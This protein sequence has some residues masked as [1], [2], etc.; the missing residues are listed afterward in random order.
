MLPRYAFTTAALLYIVMRYQSK[1]FTM[2]TGPASALG[3]SHDT[4]ITNVCIS[5]TSYNVCLEEALYV[6]DDRDERH[7]NQR[8]HDPGG[9]RKIFVE[10]EYL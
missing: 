7:N 5:V 9:I 8:G 1:M 3:A 2:Q 6:K 4:G 10:G